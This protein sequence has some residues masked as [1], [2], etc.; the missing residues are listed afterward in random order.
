MLSSGDRLV[1]IDL[2]HAVDGGQVLPWA[3]AVLDRLPPTYVEVSPSGTGLHVW[4]YGTVNRGRKIRRGRESIEVYGQGRYITVTGRPW[5][6][7]PSKLADL[8]RV[9][10]EL[11]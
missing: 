10:A 1:C 2:D 6:G 4:G 5:E 9:L 3:R 8:T 7:A 11:L